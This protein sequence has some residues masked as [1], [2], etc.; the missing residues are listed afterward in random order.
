M[1]L[2]ERPQ[3]PKGFAA[4]VADARLIVAQRVASS[5][6]LDGIPEIWRAD[7]HKEAFAEAQ[8]DRCGYCETFTLNHTPP[9]E[10]YAPKGE[11]QKLD[12]EGQ[13]GKKAS[14]SSYRVVDRETPQISATGYHWLTYE[15]TNWLL[16]CERC[17]SGWK[18]SL[19]PVAEDPHPCPPEQ[20][21]KF[22]PM[23]LNPFGPEDPVGHL[24]FTERGEIAPR[25]GSARGRETIRTCG[26]HR[27]SLRKQRK[28]FAEDAYREIFWFRDAMKRPDHESAWKSVTRLLSMGAKDHP[29]AGMVRCIVLSQLAQ[30]WPD[31][32]RLAQRLRSVARIRTKPGRANARPRRS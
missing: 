4:S 16:A 18:K 3:E 27:E 6:S 15:W 2:F 22:T 8:Q 32:E 7:T 30:R 17:N 26:L 13:E 25:S 21:K 24:E 29:H 5:Q 19:F 31:L 10:H 23:L 1:F 14:R 12:N 11:V 28:V 20:G 9:M